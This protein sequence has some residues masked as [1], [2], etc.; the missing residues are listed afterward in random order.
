MTVVHFKSFYH[1][2]IRLCDGKG[3]SQEPH[4]TFA[5][6]PHIIVWGLKFLSMPRVALRRGA[7]YTSRLTLTL[8]L[9]YITVLV[10]SHCLTSLSHSCCLSLTVL[11]S[12]SYSHCLTLVSHNEAR[13]HHCLPVESSG[14]VAFAWQAQHF[15]SPGDVCGRCGRERSF[16]SLPMAG[17]SWGVSGCFFDK[18]RCVM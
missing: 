14:G 17:A 8:L 16:A 18:S 4:S 15:D 13:Y 2:Y 12:L 9:P 1:E 6:F 5:F 11:L 3:P 7:P 10:S